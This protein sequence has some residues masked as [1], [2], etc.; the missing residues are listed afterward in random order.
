MGLTGDSQHVEEREEVPDRPG[1][2]M[3]RNGCIIRAEVL[4]I[5]AFLTGAA[6]EPAK[7]ISFFAASMAG[8][9]AFSAPSQDSLNTLSHYLS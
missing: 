5:L 2:M 7:T 6:P 1:R 4:P 9:C 8:F 3:S